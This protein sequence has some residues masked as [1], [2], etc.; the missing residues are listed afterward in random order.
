MREKRERPRGNEERR[1]REKKIEIEASPC[2]QFALHTV[3]GSERIR[4]RERG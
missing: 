1:E 2:T 4:P 3:L